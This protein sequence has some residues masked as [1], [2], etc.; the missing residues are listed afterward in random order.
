MRSDSLRSITPSM[1]SIHMSDSICTIP[2]LL[3]AAA[4]RFGDATF[5]EEAPL[6]MSFAGFRD[7][8]DHMAR[9]L[10][11]SD[12]RHGD[13]IAIW[14]PNIHEWIVA[15]LGAQSIGAVLVTLNT[16]YRGA[17]AGYI[18]RA[19]RS[20]LLFCIGDFLGTNYPRMLAREDLPALSEIVVLRG[21]PGT[22]T[23]W[24]TFLTRAAT[25]DDKKL[26]AQRSRVSPTDTSD[27]LFT[28]GTTGAPKGV[29]T[30]HGQNLRAFT[31]FCDILGIETGDRYLVMNPFFH[32][33]G[34]KAGILAC[35]IRGATLL[36][37]V[38][39]DA[40]QI[41]KR[42]AEERI[43]VLPG[44]PTLFQSLLAH[45]RLK[46]FDL[47][48]LQ[49]ATTG[50]S[51]IPVDMIRAMRDVLG[52]KTVISA[53]GLTECCGLATA[54]RPGDDA[55]IVATTSGRAIPGVEVRCADAG[56]KEVPRGEPGEIL[57]RGYNVM[58]CYFENPGAT[59][60]SIDAAGWLH[61]GDVGV[62]DA[63]GNLKITDRLK[64]MFITGGFNC[65]PAEI[66]NILAGHPEIATS[67]VIG[68]PDE[69]QGEVAMAFVV[70]KPGSSLDAAALTAWCRENMANFKVPRRIAFVEQLPLNASGKVKKI[71]LRET[72]RQFA[73][74]YP[75]P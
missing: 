51:I 27:I 26:V 28:S 14:A 36:P 49:R 52:F 64:D 57:I 19:S 42:V 47:S 23:A 7:R 21:E 68:I 67:A 37:H 30:R 13:R 24:E 60:E 53:Y 31:S 55:G 11:A 6:R 50:A 65:Y 3:Q 39:F 48:S 29:M 43:T 40:E 54:C 34:Y 45:P 63:A 32:S 22:H 1:A 18:L 71:E 2:A 56:S 58:A 10:I 8:C 16:R 72:W 4:A 69:R 73:E 41:L 74:P 12:V 20:R 61:T 75:L 33:Y 5:I 15:A 66:E 25:V 62:M 35:L 70:R 17:E 38:V 46:E 59:K 9:A 44:P